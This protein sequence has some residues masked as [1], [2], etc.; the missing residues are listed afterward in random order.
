M[1]FI[2]AHKASS[3]GM[4]AF[5][6]LALVAGGGLSPLVA[7]IGIAGLASSWFF[8]PHTV[9]SKWNWLWSAASVLVLAYALITAVST[10][11]FIG[12]GA[13]FLVWLS[14]TKL[15]NR[16][17][18]ADWQQLYLLAFLMLV[19]GSVVNTDITYGI[20]FLGFVIFA[21]W[22]FA[23]FHL[24]REI[25]T[26][27]GHLSR[28]IEIL[29][30]ESRNG[31]S[32]AVGSPANRA[33]QSPRIVEARFFIGTAV[34][35]LVVF[36]GSVIAF[37]ALPRVG[38]GFLGR[39]RASMSMAGFSDGVKLG[40]HGVIKDDST[41]IMRVEIAPT[42]GSLSA[43]AIHWRG[44][45]FDTYQNGEWMRTN[46]GPLTNSSVDN[47]GDKVRRVLL[48]DQASLNDRQEQE[49]Q[50][51][52]VQQNIYLEPME[53]NVLFGASMPQIVEW[54]DSKGK[55]E[56]RASE[57]N[58]EIRL[59]R[60]GTILY[61]VWSNPTAPEASTL[62]NAPNA[63]KDD[64]RKAYLQLP[65]EITDDTKRLATS[66]AAPFDN[67]YD[68]ATAI[69]DWLVTNL[70]YTRVQQEPGDREPIDF[71]LF[72]RKQGHCE[73]FASAFTVM[74]RAAGIAARN[75]N[76]F[77]GGEWNPAENYIAVRAGDAHSWS[78]V[79]FPGHGW[80]TFDAT[81]GGQSDELG[82][83]DDNG[84]RSKMR[85]FFDALKFQWTKWVI[86]YD[87]GSQIALLRGIGGSI[88]S[89]SSALTSGLKRAGM[90]FIRH[91]VL[92][93][94]LLT[95]A[96]IAGG[97]WLQRRKRS[98]MA[99]SSSKKASADNRRAHA[100]SALYLDITK[101][102][103]RHGIARAA[104]Q[105]PREFAFALRQ[106]SSPL[107]HHIADNMCEFTEQYSSALWSQSTADVLPIDVEQLA[108]TIRK[109]VQSFVALQQRK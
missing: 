20:C 75:V 47:V 46:R 92:L 86:D 63:Y 85:R 33:L 22:T 62:Q 14:I 3:Y 4:V 7:I 61:S 21:T 28:S 26:N 16:R 25:E 68:K 98:T 41:V 30:P 78:E 104:A 79:Y 80:V 36:L 45:A 32:A 83:G 11:D 23:L 9:P 109:Q 48:Y 96:V 6:L 56:R 38:V 44:V 53:T 77:L 87:L 105:T 39:G 76:G 2:T 13:E 106:G 100:V 73:Y 101:L 103:A 10:G 95:G 93:L 43:P 8:E 42:Y 67:Q 88:K 71:F 89:V 37:L 55:V 1:K 17:T 65:S 12:V 94:S 49:L 108:I 29:N 97:V 50:R 24:R 69:R 35:S 82:R 51:L 18:H 70:S 102:L 99:G 60:S 84:I 19:A 64:I 27:V 34:V 91:A 81:P 72:E 58:D 59:A 31:G 90:W 40:G 57:R 66:I 15:F 107:G 74:A 5:A 52:G 54:K